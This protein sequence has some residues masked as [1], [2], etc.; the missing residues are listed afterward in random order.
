MF[1]F[2]YFIFSLLQNQRTEGRTGPAWWGVG[3]SE[4]GKVVGKGDR[5]VNMVQKCVHMYADE[6]QY[7]LKLFQESGAGGDKEEQ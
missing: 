2:L 5:R 1:F 3:I 6:K 4:R 7:L